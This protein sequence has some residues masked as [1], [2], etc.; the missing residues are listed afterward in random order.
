MEKVPAASGSPDK[1]GIMPVKNIDFASLSKR[2]AT[3]I[4]GV[5]IDLDVEYDPITHIMHIVYQVRVIDP[6]LRLKDLWV[7]NV[8]TYI[9]IPEYIH[10][11]YALTSYEPASNVRKVDGGL[12]DGHWEDK[13]H[14]LSFRAAVEVICTID[15]EE[16]EFVRFHDYVFE[17]PNA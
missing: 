3:T 1:G 11:E 7:M 16:R 9:G 14:G 13:E 5:D 4:P 12:F 17:G 6:A 15:G 2:E 10:R 8:G